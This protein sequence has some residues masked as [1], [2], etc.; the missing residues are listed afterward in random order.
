M[1]LREALTKLHKIETTANLP[2]LSVLAGSIVGKLP[3]AEPG[4]EPTS[5][6]KGYRTVTP[7]AAPKLK[8]LE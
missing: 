3:G 1:G 5:M 6:V 8:R 2:R 7:T 4:A